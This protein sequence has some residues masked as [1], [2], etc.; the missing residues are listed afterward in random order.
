VQE[1]DA[2]VLLQQAHLPGQGGLGDVQS[3]GGSGEVALARDP[4]EVLEPAKVRHPWIVAS[5]GA[6][7]AIRR[8]R[9]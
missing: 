6:A 1:L 8:G 5:A 9:R 7:A 3:F 4:E 2:E